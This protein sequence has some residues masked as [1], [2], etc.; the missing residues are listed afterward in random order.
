MLSKRLHPPTETIL[1]AERDR[2]VRRLVCRV[3][4]R[5]RFWIAQP[6]VAPETALSARTEDPL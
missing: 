6:Q 4:L 1:I 5:V 3:P 2:I